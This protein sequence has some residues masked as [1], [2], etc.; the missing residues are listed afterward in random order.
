MKIKRLLLLCIVIGMVLGTAVGVM[1]SSALY[2]VTAQVNAGMQ[3]KVNGNNFIA[4][5]TNGNELSPLMYNDRTYLPLRAVAEVVGLNVDYENINNVETV[6]LGER[7]DKITDFS[8]IG[9]EAYKFHRSEDIEELTLS[10]VV[11]KLKRGYV[12]DRNSIR[13]LDLELSNKYKK[14]GFTMTTNYDKKP[15]VFKVIEGDTVI[16]TITMTSKSQ[17]FEIDV[18]NHNTITISVLAEYTV[19]KIMGSEVDEIANSKFVVSDYYVK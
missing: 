15:L 3:I 7:T 16:K 14:F 2:S 11:P 19:G 10:G 4:K 17:S 9:Q 1:A 6:I 5:D 8:A 18:A 13:T 12:S